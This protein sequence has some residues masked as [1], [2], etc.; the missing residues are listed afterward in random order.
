MVKD[1]AIELFLD[2]LASQKGT[3]GSGSAAAVIGA[4]GAALVSIVCDLTI[5]KM[6]YR[7][8]EEELKSFS[9][10]AEQL[11]R[12]LTKIIEEDVQAFDWASKLDQ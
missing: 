7:D 12:D 6:Q 3:P 4:I 9:Q 8:F 1:N 11:R 2:D 10:K 5:G